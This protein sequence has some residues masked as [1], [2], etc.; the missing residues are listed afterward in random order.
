MEQTSLFLRFGVALFIGILIGLQREF[1]VSSSDPQKEIAL[2]VR[3]F[4]LLSLVGCGAALLSGRFGSVLPL[5]AAIGAVGVLL[6]VN[7]FVEASKGHMGLTTKAAALATVLAGALCYSDQLLL[8]VALGV[9]ITAL[10]SVKIELHSFAHHLT[11]E[12]IYATVKFAVI[13][14][15]V[16]P[17]LP[18]TAFGPAPFTIFNPFKIWLFVV[19]I[20]GISFVGYVLIKAVGSEKGIGLTGLLGGLASSTA[21][22]FSLTPRSKVNPELSRSLAF[23]TVLAWTV[24]YPRVLVVVALLNPALGKAVTLPLLIPVVVGLSYCLYLYLRERTAGH[25]HHVAM[26]NPFELGLALKFGLLFAFIL[27]VSKAAAVYLGS[28]GV[29]LSSLVAGFADVDAVALSMARLSGELGGID[30]TVAARAVV[31][32]TVANA[33]LKGIVAMFGGSVEMRKAI[34]PGFVAMILTGLATALVLK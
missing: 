14:A 31:I 15:I 13:S 6:S 17:V 34:L 32:A 7:Y 25:S 21:V 12:D 9:T 24:M 33:V 29:Y 16:L 28:A 2:G 20:S 11:R 4:S 18:D 3:T 10:L 27:F 1:S 8:A 30:L 26:A 19:L 23:A 22:T 5:V